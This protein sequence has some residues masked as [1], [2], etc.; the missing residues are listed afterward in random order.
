MSSKINTCRLLIK[1]NINLLIKKYHCGR[2]SFFNASFAVQKI[3]TKSLRTKS[4]TCFRM[5]EL[6]S[7]RLVTLRLNLQH[8]EAG[9]SSLK[10][11]SSLQGP[12]LLKVNLMLLPSKM[13]KQ[14]NLAHR[15]ALDLIRK[16]LSR[17]IRTRWC[18]TKRLV[19]F[20]PKKHKQY[21]HH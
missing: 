16:N 1:I 3:P 5:K 20:A 12:S 7:R 10:M 2:S 18:W 19:N 4:P 17:Q 14:L 8:R 11:S 6:W 15:T 13:F 9:I 21:S